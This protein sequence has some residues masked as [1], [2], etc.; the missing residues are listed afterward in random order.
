[1]IRRILVI[2]LI[3]TT[4]AITAQKTS[5]SPYSFFGIGDVFNQKTVEQ[6]S[7]GG[8]GVAHKSNQYLNFVNPAANAYL[9]LSTYNIGLLNN[10]LTVKDNSGSQS[11]N[12]TRL[13]YLALGF[14]ISKKAGVSLGMQPVSSIGYSMLNKQRDASNVVTQVTQY[15]GTGGLNRLYTAFG[16]KISKAFSL[17]AEVDYTFGTIKND[18][19][20]QR[21]NVTLATKYNEKSTVKGNSVKLGIHYTKKLERNLILDV[22]LTTKLKNTLKADGTENMYSLLLGTSGVEIPKD[23]IFTGT[24][25]GTYNSPSQ[26][27]FGV[28]LGKENKWY[29]GINVEVKE[30]TTTKGFLQGITNVYKY[31]NSSKISIGGFYLPKINSISS[32]FDRV[33]YR[34]GLRFETTGILVDGTST[35]NNFTPINDF[36]INLGLG[37]PLGNRLSNLNLGLEYGQRGTIKNNLIKE[38]YFNIRLSL[39]L[40]D[41][42]FKKRRID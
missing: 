41:T 14:P 38:N 17:G 32:Y 31:G 3:L 34:G 5:S 19:L 37:L 16:I 22:G 23:T 8:I 7:M 1:M 30:K 25:K 36:G 21:A 29:A 18:I 10:H 2:F 9:R 4:V 26:T 20:N 39:S 6:S 42:W 12:S 33:T 11:S 35:G 27:N 15:E 24:L 13:S 40:N 28:G